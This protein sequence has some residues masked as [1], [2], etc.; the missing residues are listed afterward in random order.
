MNGQK[1]GRQLEIVLPQLKL[2]FLLK[3]A[4]KWVKYSQYFTYLI[5]TVQVDLNSGKY[6]NHT[7]LL[8][9]YIVSLYFEHEEGTRCSLES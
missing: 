9:Q 4:I 2:T 3:F 5:A 7:K 8:I 6:N 1:W